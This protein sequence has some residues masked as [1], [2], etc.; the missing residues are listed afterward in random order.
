MN[1][2]FTSKISILKKL[3]D[4]AFYF[5][6]TFDPFLLQVNDPS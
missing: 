1:C 3:S 2:E 4:I 6:V 5:Q